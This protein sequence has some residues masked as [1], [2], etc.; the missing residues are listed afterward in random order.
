MKDLEM[1]ASECE[2]DLSSINIQPGEVNQWLINTRAKNRWG[3]CKRCLPG[4]FDISI[5]ARLLQDSV[6]DQAAKNTIMH[7]LLHTVKGCY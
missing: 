4:I 7:E 3:Q 1:L 6:S 2:A 5:S